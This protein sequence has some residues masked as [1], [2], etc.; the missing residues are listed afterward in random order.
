[1]H[2]V[3]RIE[4]RTVMWAR[5]GLM[6]N[7][8]YPWTQDWLVGSVWRF[9]QKHWGVQDSY[10]KCERVL[11]RRPGHSTLIGSESA[12]EVVVVSIRGQEVRL[13][14]RAPPEVRIVRTEIAA[15]SGKSLDGLESK[16]AD[17]HAA[18]KFR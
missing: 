15:L 4:T 8:A 7:D 5:M 9:N 10:A 1:M 18:G 16:P 3:N 11:T 17:F 13:G 6:S 12:V 2:E 14:F